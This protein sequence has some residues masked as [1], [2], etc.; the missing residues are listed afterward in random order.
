MFEGLYFLRHEGSRVLD[1]SAF[2]LRSVGSWSV[3]MKAPRSFETSGSLNPL[4]KIPE[5][6]NFT[7]LA[8]NETGNEKCRDHVLVLQGFKGR[9]LR[10]QGTTE[11]SRYR[12]IVWI[13]KVE[14]LILSVCQVK[15]QAIER[16]NLA[17]SPLTLFLRSLRVQDLEWG[18]GWSGVV[19]PLRYVNTVPAP[20]KQRPNHQNR[21]PMQTISCYRV[22]LFCFI[23]PN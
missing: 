8:Y 21:L 9:K 2:I 16:R 20:S 19:L 11:V 13:S 3:T 1:L 4:C 6:L 14:L 23:I 10:K 18:W 7:F 5:E 15:M 12:N 22:S 17:S